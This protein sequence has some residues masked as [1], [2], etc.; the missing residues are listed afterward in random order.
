MPPTVSLFY[1][2]VAPITLI[3]MITYIA[4]L[5]V[6]TALMWCETKLRN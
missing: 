3:A 6:G 5:L 2:I 1:S 4:L